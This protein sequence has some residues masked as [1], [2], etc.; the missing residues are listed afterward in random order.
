[1]DEFHIS[2]RT[3]Q[4]PSLLSQYAG[5]LEKHGEYKGFQ[6]DFRQHRLKVSNSGRQAAIHQKRHHNLVCISNVEVTAA[7]VSPE[8]EQ[9]GA[10][11]KIQDT[12][13]A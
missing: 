1:M 3:N 11:K 2:L 13:F 6:D 9:I 10:G 4:I 12:C 7:V 8:F 5:T